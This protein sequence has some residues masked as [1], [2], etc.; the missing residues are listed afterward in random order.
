[1]IEQGHQKPEPVRIRAFRCFPVAQQGISLICQG[2]D[3]VRFIT[4]RIP[5]I[6][7]HGNTVEQVPGIHHD[8]GKDYRQYGGT[9][10]QQPHTHILHGT[11]KDQ[12]THGQ[13]P[14]EAV[15]G[16]V[17]E[18]AEPGSK[19]DISGHNRQGFP[20]SCSDCIHRSVSVPFLAAACRCRFPYIA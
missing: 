14:Q 9:S 8:S 1:M 11:G 3:Q 18:N 4:A 6:A 16:P 7:E 20:E 12:K 2:K 17:R 15:A 13:N 19:Y 10:R 5:V